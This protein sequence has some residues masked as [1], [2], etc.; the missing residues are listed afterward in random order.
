MPVL[1]RGERFKDARTVHN[2]HGKQTLSAVAENTNIAQSLIQALEDDDS[3]RDVGYN[4]VAVLAKHYGVSID[5]LCCLSED[6]SRI[7]GAVDEL[8]L[9]PQAIDNLK[10]YCSSDNASDFIDGIN[11]ILTAPRIRLLAERIS[12]FARNIKNENRYMEEYIKDNKNSFEWKTSAAFNYDMH[13]TD[14]A[15][16]L[17]KLIE[18]AAPNI[19]DRVEVYIGRAALQHELD[20]IVD[21]FKGDLDLTVGYYDYMRGPMDEK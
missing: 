7:P 10:K 18:E 5:W 9:S 19:K 11:T 4:K 13:N 20:F 12:R 1:T 17:E 16:Q 6:P 3:T 21:I 14:L 2:Q 8:G 15:L